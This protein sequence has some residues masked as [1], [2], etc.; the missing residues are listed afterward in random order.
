MKT[1]T[2][3]IIGAGLGGITSAIHLARHGIQATVLEKNNKPG[4]RCD[5]YSRDGHEFDTG[6]TLLVMPL[7]IESE[8]NTFGASMREMLDLRRVDPTYDLI[9]DDGSVFAPTSDMMKMREQLE[10]FEPGSYDGFLRYM[11]E[12][13]RHYNVSIERLLNKDFRKMTD[14]FTPANIPLLSLVKPLL[15]HYQHMSAFF[16]D[17]RL[18]AAFTFEDMYMGLSPFDAPA[19]FSLMPYSELTHG[20]WYPSGGM[21]KIIEAL[22]EVALK[23]GVAFDYNTAVERIE[24]DGHSARSVVLDDGRSLTADVIFAN[25]DL[26]YVYK[27]LLPNDP[28]VKSL[29]KKKYSCSTINFFWGMDKVYDELPGHTLFLGGDDYEKNFDQI[30]NHHGIPENPNLYVHAPARLDESMAPKGNDTLIAIVP[31]GHMKTGANQNWIEIENL[32][33]QSALD[34]LAKLGVKDID[35]HLKFEAVYTPASWKKHYNLVNGS[36][37]GLCHDLMQ[38][39][40]FR[41]HNRHAKYRNLFFVGASTHPGTGIP[42]AL[43]SARLAVQ[44]VLDELE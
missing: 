42:N 9:F 27:E 28:L 38:L 44:R 15:K 1:K 21:Y 11:Q 36:T 6:P 7:L 12:G 18:K 34:H 43:I 31:V 39:A 35:S 20:V 5:R 2:A 16:K 22:M 14:F 25:A 17:P 26:P 10:A 4:G 8:F 29:E 30:I 32:A 41:P 23:A 24:V 40:W 33:R 19:T 3:L 37:H 13:N